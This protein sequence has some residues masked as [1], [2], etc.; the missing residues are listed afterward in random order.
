VANVSN[1]DD[2][3]LVVG[4]RNSHDWGPACSCVTTCRL[5]AK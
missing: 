2:F 1:A 4:L 3:G 5:V